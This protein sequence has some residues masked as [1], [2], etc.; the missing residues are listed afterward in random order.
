MSRAR[1]R[2]LNIQGFTVENMWN[3]FRTPPSRAELDEIRLELETLRGDV[4]RWM[5]KHEMRD[6]RSQSPGQVPGP[7]TATGGS[8][9][10]EMDLPRG[11]LARRGYFSGLASS[12]LRSDPNGRSGK[13]SPAAEVPPPADR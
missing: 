9:G 12:Q 3:P 2:K 8:A 13:V 11:V 10:G 7:P 6:R 5:K 1:P 4:Y